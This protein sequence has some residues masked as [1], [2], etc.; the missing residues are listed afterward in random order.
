MRQKREPIPETRAREIH[1]DAIQ[2]DEAVKKYSVSKRTIHGWK[3]SRMAAMY[4]PGWYSEKDI[5]RMAS[6]INQ[7]SACRINGYRRIAHHTYGKVLNR[8]FASL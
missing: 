1:K 4:E 8:H 6:E 5:A 3:R 2:I 7:Q